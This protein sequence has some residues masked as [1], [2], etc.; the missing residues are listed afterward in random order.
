LRADGTYAAPA[1]SGSGDML[2]SENLSGLASYPTARS[3]LGLGN[4]DNTSDANKPVSTATSTALN[5]KANLAS[6]TFTGI[7]GLPSGQ[8]VNGVTLTT[9]GGTTNFL[10]ADGTY[11]APAGGTGGSWTLVP[12]SPVRSSNIQFTLTDTGGAN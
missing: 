1:G 3:N 6:P 7:V 11:A 4:V 9:G 12:G 5:L 8:V 10:R 2:K